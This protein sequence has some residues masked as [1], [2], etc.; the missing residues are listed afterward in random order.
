M[1][2]ET[3]RDVRTEAEDFIDAGDS[4]DVPIRIVNTERF[5]RLSVNARAA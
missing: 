5:S 3:W 4:V 2:A 1:L